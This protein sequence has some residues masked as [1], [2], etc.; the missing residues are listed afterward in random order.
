M[1]KA[2]VLS[3]KVDETT[4][5]EE[6]F[7][8]DKDSAEVNAEDQT[9]AFAEAQAHLETSASTDDSLLAEAERRV[10]LLLGD[11]VANIGELMGVEYTIEWK[12]ID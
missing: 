5:T 10:Q 4:L 11:Y 7:I 12:I 3:S 9:Y 2:K 6:S 1:P 8:V